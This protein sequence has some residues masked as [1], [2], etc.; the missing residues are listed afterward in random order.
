MQ[1]YRIATSD[2][3]QDLSGYGA[4]RYGGR[5]NRE[6]VAVLYTGSSIAL[7]AWEYFVHLP[8]TVTLKQNTFSV[9]TIELPDSSVKSLTTAELPLDWK[10]QTGVLVDITDAW[11]REEAFLAMRVPSAVV[12]GEFNYLLNPAHPLF[13]TVTVQLVEPFRFDRRAFGKQLLS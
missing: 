2:Y 11:I 5:W 3:I 6:G 12:S 13:E 8:E 1:V 9:A 10:N 7:C 4:K